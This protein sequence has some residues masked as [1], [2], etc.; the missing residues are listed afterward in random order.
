MLFRKVALFYVINKIENID[1]YNDFHRLSKVVGL[2]FFHNFRKILAKT[3]FEFQKHIFIGS[4]AD[5]RLK[6]T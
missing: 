6:C 5:I 1:G 3:T 4:C 2:Y